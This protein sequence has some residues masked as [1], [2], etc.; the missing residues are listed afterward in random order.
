MT[1]TETIAHFFGAVVQKNHAAIT[2]AYVQDEHTYVVLEGPRL[3]SRGID[4][5]RRGWQAFCD[6]DIYLQAIEWHDGPYP[7]VSD[8]MAAISGVVQLQVKL[9]QRQFERIFRITFVLIRQHGGWAIRHEHVSGAL[10]DPYDIG[11]WLKD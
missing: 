6:S 1:P 3:S 10:P 8:Q 7:E 2:A 5:I 4:N 11:D 9:G